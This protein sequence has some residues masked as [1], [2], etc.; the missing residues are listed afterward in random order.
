[1]STFD[2]EAE[3]EVDFAKYVRLLAL[4]WWLLGLGL[5]AG[6]VIGYGVSLGGSQVY[7]A[8]ATVYLGQPYSASG[9][10]QLQDLQT[11]PS[12]VAAIVHSELVI[13]TV[14]KSCG[15]KPGDFRGG[16]STQN[17][18]GAIVKNGQNPIVRISVQA[19]KGKEAACA[20][21][22]LARKVIEK[23]TAFA[24]T[25]IA[26]FQAQ[27]ANDVEQTTLINKALQAGGLS[28]SDQLLLQ[29][30]LSTAEQDRLS[31]SQLLTQAKQVEVPQLLTGAASQKVTARSRRNTVVVAALIGLVLGALAALLWDAVVPRLRPNGSQE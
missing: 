28:T 13:R 12:A 29:L 22:G 2:P 14:A 18:A 23:I 8:S 17:V 26:N 4:R 1:M 11:N 7:K 16:V 3:Q 15:A 24:N 19:K 6:A 9:N 21:N 30:R 20:A 31:T 27:V 10:I 5:V 25:K